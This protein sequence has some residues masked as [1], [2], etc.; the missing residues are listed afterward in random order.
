MNKEHIFETI[1]ASTGQTVDQV[2]TW[3]AADFREWAPSPNVS[4]LWLTATKRCP[5]R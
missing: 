5:S 4:G 2:K 3:T 1:A